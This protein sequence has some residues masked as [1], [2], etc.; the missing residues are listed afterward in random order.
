MKR[1]ID[2]F[3]NTITMYRL[4]LYY[5][6]VLVVGA[7]A[8]GL[9]HLVPYGS[10][11][12]VY[13]SIFILAVC[14]T[15]NKLFAHVFEAPTNLESVYIT[16]LI[17]VL[18]V[19]PIQTV[20]DIPFI[21]WV[22]ILAIS[23][24]FILAIGNKH[25][26][27]PV[28]IS[29][30]LTAFFLGRS[31]NWWIGDAYM[32]PLVLIGGLLIVR[33]IQRE[34]LVFTFFATAIL[35]I[36]GFTLLNNGSITQALSNTI[37]NSSL[38]FFMFV[39]LTEPLTSPSRKSMQIIFGMLVGFLFA[40]QVQLGPIFSTPELALLIG[41][42]F[43][44]IV[45]PKER[46][47]LKLTGKLKIADGIYDFI[48]SSPEKFSFVPGQ[49]MEWTIP[50]EHIDIRGNRR[51]FTLASSPTENNIRV[52]IKF[53]PH[54]SSFKKSMIAMEGQKGIVAGQRAGDFIMPEDKTKKLVFVAGGIGITPFRSMLKYLIDTNGKRDIIVIFS[55]KIASEIVYKDILDQATKN[56]NIKVIYTLTDTSTIPKAWY[57]KVGRINEAVIQQEIPDFRERLFYLSG[58]HSLVIGFEKTLKNLGLPSS[59]IKTD[60]F[61]GFV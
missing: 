48:F 35:V 56:L 16:S 4:V 12:I 31:A 30:L 6:I 2:D 23:S 40:P 15:T 49:Y 22:S 3:L 29:V 20:H 42:V 34:H 60:F 21:F 45:S 25:L 54:G 26:F 18:I 39:M 52:G 37:F 36:L 33:K 46:L 57:G 7:A 28:A 11:S 50:H 59:H 1:F 32:M 47:L 17:L 27:N 61:P 38:P 14:W 10:F 8:F 24:K 13:S 9:F 53:Y 41:N 58:P 19:A 5:L 43:A 55:N 51:Y 44:Y